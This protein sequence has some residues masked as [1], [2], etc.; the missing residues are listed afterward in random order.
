MFFEKRWID[1]R[2]PPGQARRGIF[3]SSTIPSVHPYI[4]VNFQGTAQDVMTL[5]HELGH[6][7]HQYLARDKGVLQQNTPLTTAETASI[8]GETLVFHDLVSA[9]E[10]PESRPVHAGAP[11]RVLLCHR[12]PPGGDEQ[13]RGGGAHR[14]PE[15]A[16]S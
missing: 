5:A 8:F 9:G 12:L 6:G 3:S 15:P 7:V 4:L 16:A 2:R 13:V 10:G 14:A 11:D 1:A